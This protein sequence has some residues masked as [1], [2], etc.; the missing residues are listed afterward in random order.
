MSA[1]G[2]FLQVLINGVLFG[3]MYGIAAIGLSLIFG[4]MRIIF[5]AQGTVIVFFAYVCYWLFVKA[6]VD[7]YLSLLIIVP[8]GFAVGL[9]MFYVL[10]KEA[11]ALEDR[12]V[13]LLL[14]VG[15]MYLTENV[16]LKLWSANPRFV[17]TGYA[18]L[19]LRTHGINI[20]LVR[21]LALG[22]ALAAATIVYLFLKR[23]RLGTAVKAASE[24]M[25]ATTLMGINPIWVSGI[26]FAIGLAL[27]GGAG[28]TMASVYAFDPTYGFLFALKALVA[29]ALGGIGNV[30]G[31]FA[32]GLI[33][34]LIESM[35]AYYIGPGWADAISDLVFLL[36]LIFLPSGLFGR[37]AVVKKV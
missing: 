36:V 33:L 20:S 15:L 3:T 2:I 31:A 29:L 9:G 32:G 6:H 30:F 21:L 34:G 16:M 1:G 37:R 27:A 19:T 10:F 11:A 13:S 25:Q 24:D 14:A 8:L 18:S 35:G 28:S 26:A 12:N 17:K 4:T 7:P 5:L 23:T 22:I